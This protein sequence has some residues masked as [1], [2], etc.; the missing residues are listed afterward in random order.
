LV[1]Q[2]WTSLEPGR[3]YYYL[4]TLFATDS[5]PEAQRTGSFTA[6]VRTPPQ[7]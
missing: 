1:A 6:E 2:P 3:R 4:I 7:R 5:L